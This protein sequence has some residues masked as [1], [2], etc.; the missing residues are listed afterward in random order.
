VLLN[1]LTHAINSDVT[2]TFITMDL[3]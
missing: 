1:N 3:G 2:N